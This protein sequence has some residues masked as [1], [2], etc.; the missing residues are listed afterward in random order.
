M[1]QGSTGQTETEMREQEDQADR[2]RVRE[3]LPT[4]KKGKGAEMKGIGDGE[5][6]REVTPPGV[7]SSTCF[8][9]ELG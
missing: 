8:S 7:S 3:T 9:M 1:R 2:E 5:L 6:S 4:K